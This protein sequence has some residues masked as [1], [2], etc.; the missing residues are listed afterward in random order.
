MRALLPLLPSEHVTNVEMTVITKRNR[1]LVMADQ[2]HEHGSMSTD[3]QEKTF[4]SFM[5]IVSKSTVVI[6]AALA[7]LYLING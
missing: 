5:G 6:V 1:G 3:D 7:L 2:K 4:A